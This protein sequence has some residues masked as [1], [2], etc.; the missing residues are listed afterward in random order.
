MQDPARRLGGRWPVVLI[1][2]T[3]SDAPGTAL[4]RLAGAAQPVMPRNA[5][6][7]SLPEIVVSSA[8]LAVSPS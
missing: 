7:T 4:I 5:V 8:A 1:R 3:A 6:S 2:L